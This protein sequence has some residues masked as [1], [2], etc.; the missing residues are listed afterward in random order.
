MKFVNKVALCSQGLNRKLIDFSTAAGSTATK[1]ITRLC[2]ISI[3]VKK[4]QGVIDDPRY[5]TTSF[6][7]KAQTPCCED[8]T[9][10]LGANSL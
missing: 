2:N 6:K 3:L 10:T 7:D 5:H 1:S 8:E 9:H 4:D